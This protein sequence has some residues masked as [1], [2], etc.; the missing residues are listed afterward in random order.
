MR[1]FAFFSLLCLTIALCGCGE[2]PPKQPAASA[3]PAAAP[4][5]PAQNLTVE[6]KTEAECG[7][8]CTSAKPA[9]ATPAVVEPAPEPAGG[10]C[11]K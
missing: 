11:N 1:T 10:C 9:E 2:A 4:A 5:A 6:V 7:S 3:A 8:C